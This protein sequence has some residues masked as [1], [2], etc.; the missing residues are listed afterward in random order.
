LAGARARSGVRGTRI[1]FAT[2]PCRLDG[3]VLAGLAHQPHLHDVPSGPTAFAADDPVCSVTAE[4]TEVDAVERLLEAR[5]CAVLDSL[6][7]DPPAPRGGAPWTT[8][9][10]PPPVLPRGYA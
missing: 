1:V 7:P 6:L 3:A 10:A 5:A 4:A 2:G 8:A 9:A